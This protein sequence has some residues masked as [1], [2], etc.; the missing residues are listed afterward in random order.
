MVRQLRPVLRIRDRCPVCPVCNVGVLWPNGWLDQDATRYG[1][2]PRPRRHCVRWESSSTRKG[3]QQLPTFRP[4]STVAKRSP[5]SATA[6]LLLNRSTSGDVTG[7][8]AD[9]ISAVY[10]GHS[11]ELS[12]DLTHSRQELLQ[13][14][15]VTIIDLVNLDSVIDKYQ[16]VVPSITRGSPTDAISDWTLIVCAGVL[17]RRLSSSLL[18]VCTV[19]HSVGFSVRPL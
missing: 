7:E 10:V 18:Q 3:A 14:H 12:W 19:G 17:S 13:Q 16:T 11:E 8:E 1:G 2:R 6:E 9:S 5:I 15:Y 4:T